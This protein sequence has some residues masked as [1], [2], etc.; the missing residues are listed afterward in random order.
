MT[1]EE[2]VASIDRNPEDCNPCIE[3]WV[4]IKLIQEAC[5]KQREICANI[6]N[7]FPEER[8]SYASFEYA[9]EPTWEE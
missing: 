4:V 2:K 7:S 6:W 1:I 9:P 5:A 3:R 8:L